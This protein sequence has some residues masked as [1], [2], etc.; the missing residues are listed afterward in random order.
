MKR[1][2]MI[3]IVDN[4][5]DDEFTALAV[6]PIALTADPEFWRT[7]G[8]ACQVIET[9]F[10]FNSPTDA[11]ELLTLYFGESRFHTGDMRLTYR[12]GLFTRLVAD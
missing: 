12:V 5:G 7:Q 1:G 6:D 3:A 10:E 9:Y 11:H 4:L 8:F 2:G